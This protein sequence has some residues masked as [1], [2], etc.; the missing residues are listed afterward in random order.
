MRG[1]KY[2]DAGTLGSMKK[3]AVYS[4]YVRREIV[5]QN[6]L[7]LRSEEEPEPANQEM[8]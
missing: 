4:G 6:S 8:V 7:A 3:N 5:F 1:I 2:Y